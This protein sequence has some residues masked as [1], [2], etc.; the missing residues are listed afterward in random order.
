MNIIDIP[1][2]SFGP[3]S[4]VNM[5]QTSNNNPSTESDSGRNVR[6]RFVNGYGLIPH[7]SNVVF[8]EGLV[9]VDIEHMMGDHPERQ[10]SIMYLQLIHV[11]SGSITGQS[12]MT[13]YQSYFKKNSK[14]DG[15]MNSQYYRLFLFRDI[16][17]NDGQV[18]YIVEGKNRNDRLWERDPSLCDNGCVTIGT[19][20]SIINPQPITSWF[21]NEIPII[22]CRGSCF[23]MKC[24]GGSFEVNMDT[25]IT[26]NV[27]RCFV[28]NNVDVDVLSTDV[29]STKCSGLFCDRQRSLEISRG[30]RS[31]GCYSMNN[32]V[33]S[34]A[35]LH[36]VE[37][38]VGGVQLFSMDDFSSLNFINL[39][40]KSRFSWN[41][42]ANLLDFTPA[43]FQM[44][45]CITKIIELIN[46]NGGFT[47][48]G[49]YK[50]G[51]IN[52]ISNDESQNDV[53]SG[54]VVHHIVSIYPTNPDVLKMHEFENNQFSFSNIS[55]E[56][57]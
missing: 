57:N 35:I 31:C 7:D 16:S 44:Q 48:I 12:G 42:R 5:V 49:W 53:E 32:R 33:S 22:E 23:V 17:T 54:E 45:K 19:Y 56:S 15:S 26:T 51:E 9:E 50:R 41:V 27:T 2:F 47:V 37:I 28:K 43:Y 46:N 21:C 40:L 8:P 38:S 55:N 6:T 13:P 3:S 34:I 30:N 52:D 1:N 11:V 29:H 25:S 39:Y 10:M 14:K 24:V 4:T 18:V 20:I 36:R